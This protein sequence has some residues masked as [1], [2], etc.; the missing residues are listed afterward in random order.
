MNPTTYAEKLRL[1]ADTTT[2][3]APTAGS[4]A[5]EW[6]TKIDGKDTRCGMPAKWWRDVPRGKW[7]LCEAHFDL[8]LG[9]HNKRAQ[10]EE[11]HE[12][13]KCLPPPNLK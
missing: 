4:A 7:F 2:P 5:C 1:A 8:L 3:L 13:G 12:W 11:M 10:M 6:L 9:S